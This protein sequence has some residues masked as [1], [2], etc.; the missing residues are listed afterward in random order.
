MLV[1]Y[2]D[3]TRFYSGKMLKL[4]A[5][6]TSL[7]LFLF[8][9][10]GG[11]YTFGQQ[12]AAKSQ[13][14]SDVDGKPVLLKHLPDA[15]K[16]APNAIFGTDKAGLEN[17]IR[18]QPALQSL[19]FPFGTEYV[20][21]AYPEGRL[22]IV[23]YTNPQSSAEADSKIQQYLSAQASPPFVYRRIGNYNAFVFDVPDAVAANGLLDQVKYEKTVQWLGEDPY[24]LKKLERYMVT[25]SRDIMISTV[26]AIV[27][28]LLASILAGIIAGF[29]F[30]RVR[31]QKRAHRTA[32]SDAGGLTRLNLD[33]LSE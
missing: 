32:F 14:I 3:F 24:I 5:V 6:L 19:E 31:D 17:V 23:E 26:L 27:F 7:P 10:S 22:L 20:T 8:L 29:I 21:A 33:G 4:R 30:F 2:S 18:N 12:S 9:I 11:V 13:E 1:F 16:V 15:E 28:G 25:T